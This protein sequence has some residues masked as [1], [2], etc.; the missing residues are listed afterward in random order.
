MVRTHPFSVVFGP[1]GSGKSSL[2]RAGLIPRLRSSRDP[3]PR[4]AAIRILTPGPRP[5]PEHAKLLVPDPDAGDTWLLVDQFEELFTLCQDA[6]ARTAFIDLL[7]AAREPDSR[8]RVV[9]GVRA[10]FYARCLE[11][12]GLAV[13]VREASLPVGPMA[14]AQLREVIVKSAASQGLVVERALTARLLAEVAGEPGGLPLLSHA[15]LE[16]W[17]RRRGRTLTEEAYKAAG[18]LHGALA[19]TAEDVYARLALEQRE[20]ARHVLLRMITPGAGAPDTRRPVQW[21]ELTEGDPGG[22]RF[23]LERLAQARLVT[24]AEGTAGLRTRRS[25]R[26]GPDCAP[27]SRRAANASWPTVGCPKPLGCG[28]NSTTTRASCT[29]EPSWRPPGTGR[30]MGQGATN[31]IQRN[32]PSWI[33]ASNSPTPNAPWPPD[34]VVV[35]AC[36]LCASPCCWSWWQASDPSPCTNGNTPNTNGK[37]PSPVNWPPRPSGWPHPSRPSPNC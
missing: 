34:A 24:L 30:A 37:S 31:S 15:L 10:D 7:L 21:S 22:I 13:A 32:G 14:P 19:Q 36:S 20:L 11:H 4:P 1:S 9:L 2:L 35:S 18:G 8:L 6:D 12:P 27:G 28:R 25:S 5:L 17:R 23:V 16:T 33:P 3:L 26:P 29:G